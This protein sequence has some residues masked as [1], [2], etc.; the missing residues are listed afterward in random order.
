MEFEDL[1]PRKQPPKPRDL[2]TWGVEEL[3]AYIANLNAEIERARAVIKSKQGHR[4]AAD[5]FFKK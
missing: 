1:E 4:A 5:A 3:N 2:S